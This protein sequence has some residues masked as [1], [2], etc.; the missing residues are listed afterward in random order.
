LTGAGGA[1]SVRL[2]GKLT[3]FLIALS[4]SGDLADRFQDDA[5]RDE[6][7]RE[8]DLEGHPA[9]QRGATLQDVQAAAAAEHTGGEELWIETW[10][11]VDEGPITDSWI[12]SA[13]GGPDPPSS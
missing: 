8:W 6:L 5:R 4:E 11:L 7:L 12:L 1:G 3:D 10:I 9:L 13:E 2:V